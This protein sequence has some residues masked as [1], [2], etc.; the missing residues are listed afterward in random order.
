MASMKEESRIKKG[1]T[2]AVVRRH[3]SCSCFAGVL[4]LALALLLGTGCMNCT[5]YIE[6]PTIASST[7]QALC[8]R[9][10]VPLV[11]V[12]GWQ[13]SRFVIYDS[14]YMQAVV[15]TCNPNFILRSE[16]LHKTARYHVPTKITYCQLCQ[17]AVAANLARPDAA[18]PPSWWT[19]LITGV[20]LSKS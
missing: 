17:K 2:R 6:H 16:S 11:T 14:V 12:D 10:H 4:V 3:S 7:G 1:A 13:E 5:R 20:H 19:E 9:H 8:A 18:R 15:E